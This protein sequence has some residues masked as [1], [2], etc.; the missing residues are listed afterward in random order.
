MIVMIQRMINLD[1]F[2][3]SYIKKSIKDMIVIAKVWE[4]K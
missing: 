3:I 2:S 4:R 1:I